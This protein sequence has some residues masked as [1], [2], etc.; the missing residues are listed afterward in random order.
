MDREKILFLCSKQV[1][2]RLYDNIFRWVE[3]LSPEDCVMCFDSSELE[4]E[5]LKALLV[6]KIP[7]ILFVMN[8]F[9]DNG[10]IQIKSA[11][12]ENRLLVV[13]LKRDE[14]RGK[15]QTP[16]LRNEFVLTMAKEIVCGYVNPNG[17]I[18]PILAGRKNVRYLEKEDSM[19][20]AAEPDTKPHHWSVGEDKTLLRMYYEDMGLYAIRKR[21]GRSY[22]A[23]RNRIR[24]LVLT[25]EALKGREFEEY[26][27]GLLKVDDKKGFTLLE[28]R[29]DK[30]F[31]NVIPENNSYPDFVI[32]CNKMNE[33][34]AIECKWRSVMPRNLK[35]YLVNNEQYDRYKRFSEERKIPV[36][37]FLGIGGDACQPQ[38]LYLIPLDIIQKV[39]DGRY[40]LKEFRRELKPIVVEDFNL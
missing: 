27:L 1:P 7:T 35:K 16:R 28:W 39:I 6:N 37:L 20:M 30:M 5:L 17:S 21:L 40:A 29:G 2:F 36:F 3:T 10:D 33:E 13:E 31:G 26:V 23:T 15:G 12:D 34:I 4:E 14:P 9:R 22:Q 8:N 25:D 24:A 32:K 19:M 38:E 18:F 11:M